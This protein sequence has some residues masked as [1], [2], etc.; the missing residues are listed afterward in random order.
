MEA[1]SWPGNPV[2]VSIRRRLMGERPSGNRKRLA[3]K[4]PSHSTGYEIT[5]ISPGLN[6]TLGFR[7]VLSK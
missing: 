7:E 3:L 1:V 6:H 2:C 4:F 5:K